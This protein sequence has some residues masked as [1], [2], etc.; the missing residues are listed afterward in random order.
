MSA[1]SKVSDAIEQVHA[2]PDVFVVRVP[3]KNISTNATNCY[4]VRDGGEVLVVDTGAPTDEAARVLL[5]ALDEL[6]VDRSCAS[7]FLTHFHLDH[8]GL[9]D[10]VVPDGARLYVSAVECGEAR[11]SHTAVCL[12]S[13]QRTFVRE[14]LSFSDASAYARLG[15]EPSL[16]DT[17]RVKTTFV[18]E[19]EEIPVGGL[20]LRVVETPGHTPGHLSLFEPSSRILFGG[21]HV[22]FVISPSIALFQRGVNGLT[23]YLDSLRKVRRLDAAQLFHSHG[24]I[25]PDFEDRIAWLERHHTERL[26]EVCRIVADAPGLSGYE[27]LRSITWNVPHDTWEDISFLQRWCIVTEGIVY[28][29]HVVGQGR[30]MRSPD[31]D[32]VYRYYPKA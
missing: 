6:G 9:V 2:A 8:A 23:A 3:F 31:I 27:A 21:D 30:V 12:E 17:S 22:L 26:D 15:V 10:R 11:A 18:H 32:G 13:L 19:G 7:W 4:V 29:D 1:R 20:R 14:G 28:L 25:R 16:F 24:D 5:G